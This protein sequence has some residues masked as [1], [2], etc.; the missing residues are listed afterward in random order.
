MEQV[1]LKLEANRFRQRIRILYYARIFLLLTGFSMVIIPSLQKKF[2]LSGLIPYLIFFIMI[3]YSTINYYIKSLLTLKIFTFITLIFDLS[4]VTFLI[5]SSGGL[6]SPILS[7]QLVYLIFF[8]AL[9]QKPFFI[10]PPLLVIPIITRVDI[11][12]GETDLVNSIFTIFWFSSLSGIIVYFIVLLNNKTHQNAL[13]IYKFQQELK[14][15]HLL[16]EKNKIARD[17]HDGV[18]GGLSSLILQTEYILSLTKDVVS[19]DILKEIKELKF[20]AEESMDEIRR[21]LSVIKNS[22][23][24]E[25]S[26]LIYIENFNYKNKIR[27][28]KK[29]ESGK[30]KIAVKEQISI[31]RVFQEIMTNAL[32]HS[33][34]DHIDVYLKI[35]ISNVYLEVKDYGI[36]FDQNKEYVGHF[37]LKNLK[38]R[39]ELLN[40]TIYISFNKEEGS[41]FKILIPNVM[42]V[43]ESSLELF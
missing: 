40:G 28:S 27:V 25:N 18:G 34:S 3:C 15:N 11:L 33:Q 2:G 12:L 19:E 31:F 38:E 9:F 41:V 5:V 22:F 1:S 21:S 13:N 29:I 6:E 10:L 37:G 26:I 16:E 36:G 32:K 24:F 4:A 23:D 42:K 30:I 17:L 35:D 43:D 14:E 39:V 8:T 20:Y 7:T